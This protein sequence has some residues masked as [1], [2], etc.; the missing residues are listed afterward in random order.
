MVNSW[1]SPKIIYLYLLL[2]KIPVNSPKIIYLFLLLWKIPGNSPKIIYLYLLL[3]KIHGNSP[4]II[5]YI[6]FYGTLYLLVSAFIEK[7]WRFSK[8]NLIVSACMENS[9]KII[10]LYLLL[11]TIPGYKS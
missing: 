11:W 6:C 9:P 1:K 10:Y 4:K 2:W 8:E 5:F 3:W 7:S